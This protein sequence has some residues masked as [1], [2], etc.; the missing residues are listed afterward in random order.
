MRSHTASHGPHGGHLRCGCKSKQPSA[1]RK[2]QNLRPWSVLLFLSWELRSVVTLTVAYWPVRKPVGATALAGVTLL[3]RGD[4]PQSHG[5]KSV[6][7]WS[8]S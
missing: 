5:G 2:R 6:L 4:R 3:T 7:F 8:L 1:A